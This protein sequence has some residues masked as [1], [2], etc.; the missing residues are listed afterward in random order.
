MTRRTPRQPRLAFLRTF[1]VV[2]R[3][4]SFSLAAKELNLT[5][6]AVSRQIREVEETLGVKLFNRLPRGIELTGAGRT[7]LRAPRLAAVPGA[8]T[9]AARPTG[10]ARTGPTVRTGAAVAGAVIGL[11]HGHSVSSVTLPGSVAMAGQ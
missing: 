6:S 1:E 7:L 3:Q 5:I 2:A 10:P 9:A 11:G 8:G 4:R